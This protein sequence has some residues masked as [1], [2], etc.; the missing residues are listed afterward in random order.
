M[1]PLPAGQRVGRLLLVDDERGNGTL[2]HRV[3]KQG[4][5]IE[6]EEW[7][8]C[9]CNETFMMEYDLPAGYDMRDRPVCRNCSD[10]EARC[11]KQDSI[12]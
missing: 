6:R 7:E 9:Q 11:K 5:K 3:H 10:K 12:T 1:R 4:D 8:C 2:L